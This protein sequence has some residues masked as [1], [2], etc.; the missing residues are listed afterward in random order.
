MGVVF[1]VS[2]VVEVL[3]MRGEGQELQR[4]SV[5]RA[6][7][8]AEQC[9]GPETEDGELSVVRH[10]GGREL[11]PWSCT[12]LEMLAGLRRDCAGGMQD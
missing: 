5:N 12:G 11:R 6:M 8:P 4:N 9:C 10:W 3:S 7:F 1:C 2:A